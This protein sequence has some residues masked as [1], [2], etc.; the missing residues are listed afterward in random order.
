MSDEGIE[1]NKNRAGG[2][3][4]LRACLKINI[5]KVITIFNMGEQI[6]RKLYQTD[7]SDKEWEKI[8]PHIPIPKTKRGRKRDHLLREIMNAIFYVMRS[9]CTWRMLPHDFP[10]W[11]TVY[12]YFRLL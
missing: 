1:S 11:K 9:S 7:L 8:K 6:K 12:R 3:I 4:N 2:V 10:P 5:L